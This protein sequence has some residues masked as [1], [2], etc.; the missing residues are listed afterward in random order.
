MDGH[1]ARKRF[2]QHFLADPGVVE[3]VVDAIRPREGQHI[4]EIGPGLAA[5][6]DALLDR[7]ETVQA[8]ELDR[9]LAARL[10]RRHPDGRLI[11]HEADALAF[12]FGRALPAA[13]QR[14][15]VVGNLPYNISSPLL[16]RL[17]D[18]R[19]IV[20][21]QHFML[22]RE[23]VERIVG[24]PGTSDYGRLSVLMQAFFVCVRLFDVPPHAFDPPPRVN[25]AVV[26]MIVRRDR[27]H[28]DPGPLQEVLAVAFGQR[29]KM[30]R[31]TLLPWLAQRGVSCEEIDPTARAEQV[32]VDTW[33][34]LAARLVAAGGGSG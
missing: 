25:S 31:G 30:L 11:L 9:D 24:E 14:L 8:I 6:T 27:L 23:V 12:D 3:A 18:Y 20:E 32:D 1:R 5:L 4:V 21:D 19:A 26:R 33:R 15:R 34:A 17:L 28:E 13:D 29:R 2:G 10:R 22:Q 7:V 16:V